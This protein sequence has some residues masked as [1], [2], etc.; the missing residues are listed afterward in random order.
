[1]AAGGQYI[2]YMKD[3]SNSKLFALLRFNWQKIIGL[4]LL[5]PPLWSVIVFV[6]KGYIF[7][8]AIDDTLYILSKTQFPL[9]LGLMAVA[10]SYLIVKSAHT[11]E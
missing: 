11:T 6:I 9:Y 4:L 2:I 1:M 8:I 5:L 7:D 10:G 3:S